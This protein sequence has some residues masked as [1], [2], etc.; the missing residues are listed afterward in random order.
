MAQ[1]PGAQR[2][3]GAWSKGYKTIEQKNA[4]EILEFLAGPTFQGRNAFNGD[5]FAAAGYVATYLHGL[6]LQPGGE[7]GSYLRRFT[8]LESTLDPAGTE[9][10]SEDGQLVYPYGADFNAQSAFASADSLKFAFVHL[11]QGADPNKLDWSLVKGRCVILTRESR[12]N[13]FI[14][15][16][17]A[18]RNPTVTFDQTVASFEP[19]APSRAIIERAVKD[20]PDPRVAKYLNFRLSAKAQEAIATK[21]GAA[22]FL[23]H[24]A[25]EPSIEVSDVPFKLTIKV[26]SKENAA[27]NV[28]AVFPGTDPALKDECV[29]V[30]SHLDHFGASADGIRFGADDNGSGCTANMLLARAIS[31]NPV[32]PKRTV[33][34][35]FW[36]MEESGT[37]G[38]FAYSANPLFP[39]A[40]TVAY[41]NMDMVSRN[42]E[43]TI[44]IPEN[45][46]RSAYAGIVQLNSPDFAKLLADTNRYV[47]L[48]LKNDKED[49]TERSDTRNFVFRGVPTV[50]VFTGEHKDY[51]RATDTVDKVNFEKLTNVAKWVYLTVEELADGR[52]RPKF[53]KTIWTGPADASYQGHAKLPEGTVLPK[54]ARLTVELVEE[55]QT[56]PVDS[57][58][59]PTITSTPF[60]ITLS[61]TKLDPK[62]TY[63]LLFRVASGKTTL[64]TNE[65]PISASPTG[66]TRPQDVPLKK[67]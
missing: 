22:K 5:W 11:P 36:T 61:K 66:W 18:R 44:D 41:V 52:P 7:G 28:V 31:E 40:K 12:S 29:L 42:E 2:V 3:P 38:S 35:C 62:K 59:A 53:E 8:F 10:R 63:R 43:Y 46:V 16:V 55:G 60:E 30:G 1:Y 27:A 26:T 23:A 45:N 19:V 6:G 25:T 13:Q 57:M 49:R 21:C 48:H 4:K 15:D 37:Y 34:F 51:H 9:L 33:V 50:K 56:N 58:T 65:S 14:L 39:I 20:F 54:D 24:S 32:K 47:N 64:F 67:A 17:L